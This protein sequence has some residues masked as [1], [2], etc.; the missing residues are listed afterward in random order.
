MRNR[1]DSK[2]IYVK[3]WEK[4]L[5]LEGSV[6]DSEKGSKGSKNGK[7]LWLIKTIIAIIHLVFHIYWF[8]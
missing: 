5:I 2:R 4:I 1:K 6:K 3:R 7:L 8:K